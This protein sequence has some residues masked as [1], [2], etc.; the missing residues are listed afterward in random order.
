MQSEVRKLV[1]DSHNA[2]KLLAQFVKDKTLTD[3]RND[4]LLRSAVERQ[5]IIIGEALSRAFKIEPTLSNSITNVQ[6]IISFRNILVHGYAV[7]EDDT[8]WG[9]IEKDLRILLNE[10]G[11]LLGQ[12]DEGP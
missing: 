5:F 3:Y 9:V 11:A 4:A 12:D 7:V 10:L 6:R 8:V 2:C 1:Y